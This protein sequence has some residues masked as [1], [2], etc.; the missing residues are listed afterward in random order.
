MPQER[1]SDSRGL[2]EHQTAVQPSEQLQES[3]NQRIH[4]GSN[5]QPPKVP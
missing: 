3:W 4:E 5:S 2:R 1:G